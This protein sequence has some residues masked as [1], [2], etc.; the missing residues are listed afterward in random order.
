[1]SLTLVGS[2]FSLTKSKLKCELKTQN[3]ERAE[4]RTLNTPFLPGDQPKNASSERSPNSRRQIR[5]CMDL[6][7]R[8]YQL[9][10]LTKLSLFDERFLIDEKVAIDEGEKSHAAIARK[11]RESAEKGPWLKSDKVKCGENPSAI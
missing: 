6:W 11:R 8:K 9:T 3:S 1:L 7:Y 4:A 5:L 2:C 10:R